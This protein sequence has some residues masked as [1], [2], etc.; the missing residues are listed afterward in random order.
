MANRRVLTL[1]PASV[2]VIS[3]MIGTGIF[4]TTGLMAGMGA[5][6]GDILLAWLLGG[7]IALCGALC[8]GEVGA[9]LPQSGGEYH[10]ISRLVHPALGFI[11]GILTLC[12]SFSAPI[13]AAAIAMNLYIS[14]VVDGWPVRIMAAGIILLLALLHSYDLRLGSRFQVFITILEVLLI[15]AFIGGVFLGSSAVR[16]D[17][18]FDVSPN[19]LLSS[20]FAV[21]LVFVAFAYSGWN[22]AAY[23][24]AELNRPERT[25]P[26]ALLIG[27][28]IV[29]ALYLLLNVSY[30]MV[31]SP[32]ELAGVEQ[33]GFVVGERLWGTSAANAISLTL[34]FIMLCPTSAMLMIGPRV[35]EAMARDGFLPEVFGRLNSRNVP[36]R[37]VALLAVIA[38]IIAVTSSFG[39]LLI[40]IGFTL[41]V[42]SALT[43]VGLFRLRRQGRS[44][45]K[46]CIGYPVTPIIFLAFTVWMT[47]WSI[48]SQ[49]AAT[50]AGILTLA[51]AYGIYLL[52]VRSMG[53]IPEV[54]VEETVGD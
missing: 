34:A 44:R 27:T 40:Y 15:V 33:V 49:P 37:S 30:L 16:T 54:V 38:V 22:A 42:F 3:N 4:T 17:T 39:P 1:T 52:R 19:F 21:V 43:V 13:A 10:Y 53:A 32:S 2:A 36:S 51:G 20:P 7:V 47:V 28:G 25:L 12:V 29:T 18:G 11:S 26:R 46:I 50:I 31:V 14:R 9:N 5:A 23:I 48:Q 45:H 6:G 35:A 41:N 8:Y 24:G